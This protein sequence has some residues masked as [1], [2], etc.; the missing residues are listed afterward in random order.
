MNRQFTEVPPAA[1]VTPLFI[2][3]SNEYTN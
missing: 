1:R 2:R 3:K